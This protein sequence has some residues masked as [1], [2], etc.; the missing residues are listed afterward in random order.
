MCPQQALSSVPA[1]MKKVIISY[2]NNTPQKAMMIK[3]TAMC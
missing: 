3:I 1:T 2:K